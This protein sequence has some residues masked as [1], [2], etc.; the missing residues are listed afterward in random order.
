MTTPSQSSAA[1]KLDGFIRH[2]RG[3]APVRLAMVAGLAALLS[4]VATPVFTASFT[5]LHMA[6]YGTLFLAV[7]VAARDTDPALALRKLT[8]RTALIIF[9]ISLH[10]CWM[11]LFVRG[12][13][14]S[15][16][17]KMEAGLLIIGVLM[18]TALQVHMTRIGYLAA[19][20]PAIGAMIWIALNQKGPTAGPHF[21]ASVLVFV[22]ALVAAS[23]RQ[24][25]TDRTLWKARQELEEKNAAL[26]ALVV[27]AEAASRAKSDFMAMTSHEIR[28][29]LNAVLGLTEA[30]NRSRL[31]SRQKAMTVGVLEAGAL[32]K[33][34][35]DSV[36]DISRIEAGK[37]T[38]DIAP[39]DLARM[40]ETVVR[41]WEPRAAERG[42]AL[43]LDL[44]GLPRPCGLLADGGKIEQALVNLISNAL[45]FSPRGGTATVRLSAR[46]EAGAMAVVVEVLDQG[47]G[48]PVADRERIFQS[49]EQTEDGRVLGGAGLGLAISAGNLALMGGSIGVGDAPGGGAAFRFALTAPEAQ[50]VAAPAVEEAAPALDA[51]RP[52]RVLAA[53]DNPANRHVLRVLLEPLPVALT[54]AENGA[55]ALDLFARE[56]FDIV[57][58]DATM[59]VMD[60]LSALR[61]LRAGGGRGAS[62]PVWMLTANVFEEDVRRYLDAG[63]D[64]V[65]R[66]PIDLGELFAALAGAAERVR[67]EAVAA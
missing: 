1:L 5:A 14:T 64:G 48:V 12:A 8:V 11:A 16:A 17:V 35:L 40:A 32:L 51:D 41:V 63:A 45:K 15:L 37:M 36:L 57:L 21:A 18:F 52:L 46:R 2:Y 34:L 7:E 55:E 62:T 3:M 54:L 44:S 67:L 59:P 38:L 65:V 47:P 9:L 25:S 28:T 6:L 61:I 19:I 31:T 23:W 30:L 58:M 60:G 49:F 66:K 4:T 24:Q 13:T 22:C 10:V 56:T 42:V 20:A 27:Q 26:T 53:E 33:R 50:V 43:A 39:F 29:P